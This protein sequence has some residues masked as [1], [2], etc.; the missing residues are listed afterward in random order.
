MLPLVLPDVLSHPMTRRSM[1]HAPARV[2]T[3]TSRRRWDFLRAALAAALRSLSRV[4]Y[5][6]RASFAPP[7]VTLPVRQAP[8]QSRLACAGVQRTG[9]TAGGSEASPPWPDLE[10]QRPRR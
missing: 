8:V 7:G 9:L 4:A 10:A 2:W 3:G 6:P 1:S 5:P